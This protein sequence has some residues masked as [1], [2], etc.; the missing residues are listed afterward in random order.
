MSTSPPTGEELWH[1][2]NRRLGGPQGLCERDSIQGLTSPYRTYYTD[3]FV[4]NNNNNN[5]NKHFSA[6]TCRGTFTFPKLWVRLGEGVSSYPLRSM[7]VPQEF[8]CYIIIIII[9]HKLLF[10]K[11]NLSWRWY[12]GTHYNKSHLP[13]KSFTPSH[14]HTHTYTH[15]H[16][17]TH[18]GVLFMSGPCV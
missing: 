8:S 5:N 13:D 9:V 18:L 3:Y 1:P 16:T 7:I 15:T 6:S 2:W 12:C 14:T 11:N 10:W 17:H 4:R